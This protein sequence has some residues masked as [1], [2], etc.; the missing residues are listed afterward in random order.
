MVT[1][2]EIT[3]TTTTTIEEKYKVL[4]PES[5]QETFMSD[6]EDEGGECFSSFQDVFSY[7]FIYF[8]FVFFFSFALFKGED[9]LDPSIYGPTESSSAK[10]GQVLVDDRHPDMSGYEGVTLGQNCKSLLFFSLLLVP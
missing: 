9:L 2:Q 5:M 3:T 6:S 8:I 10:G 1:E 7:V 4:A